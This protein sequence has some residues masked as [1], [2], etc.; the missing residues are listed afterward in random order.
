M[1]G[2]DLLIVLPLAILTSL[3][4]QYYFGFRKEAP[5]TV[6]EDKRPL[7]LDVSFIEK[8]NLKLSMH[9]ISF[10]PRVLPLKM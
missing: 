4:I 3:G 1:N 8:K 9:G 7:N 6:Q 2:R 10:P 5:A